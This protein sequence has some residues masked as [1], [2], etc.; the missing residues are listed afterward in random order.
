M[1]NNTMKFSLLVLSV[2]ISPEVFAKPTAGNH[3]V[4]K[5][6]ISRSAR[7]QGRVMG[8]E[9]ADIEDYPYAVSLKYKKRDRSQEFQHYCGGTLVGLFLDK[10]SNFYVCVE[11]STNEI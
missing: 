5:L 9:E 11:F 7:R 10:T 8:G 6:R 2:F 4:G 3:N 1:P